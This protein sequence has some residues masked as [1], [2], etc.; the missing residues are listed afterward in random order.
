MSEHAIYSPSSA[1]RNMHCKGAIALCKVHGVVGKT[2][3]HS[4]QGDVA[5]DF[6]KQ[7]L[8]TIHSMREYDF[9]LIPDKE[10]REHVINYCS[11]IGE[12]NKQFR[13]SHSGVVHYIEQK[14]KYDDDF[15]GT[16]DYVLTGFNKKTHL[17]EA[18]ICDFKYG[19][20]VVV[21]AEENEQLLSYAICL[22]H[23]LGTLFDKVHCFI[24]QPRT[25]GKEFTRWSVTQEVLSAATKELVKNK[26]EC[27][28]IMNTALAV[29][30]EPTDLVV[31]EWCRFCPGKQHRVC[32]AFMAD[33]N[34]TRLKILS[35]VPEIPKVES[36]TLEQK[37]EIFKRRKV[38]KS[39]IDDVCEDLI[40]IA[41][42]GT[43]IPDHKIVEGQRR[44]SWIKD[45]KKV[46]VEL[47][48]LGVDKPVK[49]SI[50]GIGEVEKQIGEGK[51][52]ELVTLSPLKY[53]LV[54]VDDKRAPIQVVGIDD[55]PE[56]TFTE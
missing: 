31:G 54:P 28:A 49:E 50:I 16:A 5:H 20:G 27:L 4:E 29:Q 13:K 10:M 19:K 30:A 25:P 41:T 12:I 14:V 6:N 24:F 22:Q 15:W 55:L 7:A 11:F 34:S 18:I 56:I 21:D 47:K 36:L 33:A 23:T 53:Q 26:E 37:V 8:T 51:I 35:T 2:S 42:K 52:S 46:A 48:K 1:Y 39:I 9:N 45:V 38:L 40:Q 3:A 43:P 44:R 32:K 17:S